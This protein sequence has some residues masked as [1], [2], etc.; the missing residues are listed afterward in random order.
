MNISNQNSYRESPTKHILLDFES[1][2]LASPAH[3]QM[4]NKYK[5]VPPMPGSDPYQDVELTPWIKVRPCDPKEFIER[6]RE[7]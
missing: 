5:H 3:D 7:K 4:A 2:S 1:F 6:R